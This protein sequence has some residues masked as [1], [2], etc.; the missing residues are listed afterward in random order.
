MWMMV[1]WIRCDGG[2]PIGLFS[3]PTETQSDLSMSF[4]LLSQ[5][6]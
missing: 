5:Y 1:P 4:M 6:V 2:T 3:G